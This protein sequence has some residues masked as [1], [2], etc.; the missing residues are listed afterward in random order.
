MRSKKQR[1]AVAVAI[2]AERQSMN[3]L[4]QPVAEVAALLASLP[5]AV[6]VVLGGSRALAHSDA[7]S[8]WDFGLYYRGGIDLTALTARGTVFPPGVLGTV[9]ERRCLASLRRRK[10][11]C[12]PA[13]P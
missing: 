9:D 5:G 7:A 4:P 12:D 8:D 13:G 6:T 11:R 2:V 1:Q 3:D 10:G